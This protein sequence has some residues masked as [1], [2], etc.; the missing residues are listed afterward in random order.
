MKENLPKVSPTPADGLSRQTAD[1]YIEVD[2]N[3]DLELRHFKAILTLSG[4]SGMDLN[5]PQN[6]IAAG[7]AL[8]GAID[9]LSQTVR[10]WLWLDRRGKPYGAE[11]T[12]NPDAFESVAM[13]EI[14]WML[15][16]VSGLIQED[17]ASEGTKGG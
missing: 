4:M 6:A 8:I 13:D 12:D 14:N 17:A 3:V 9:L 1:S 11:P 7:K 5:N 10:G 16:A 15:E 2:V